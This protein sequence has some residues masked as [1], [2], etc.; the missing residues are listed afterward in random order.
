MRNGNKDAGVEVPEAFQSSYR[1]YEE[2]KLI[3]ATDKAVSMIISSYR[4]Y[5]EWKRTSEQIVQTV[6]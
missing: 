6:S 4:T 5:E 2:W 3:S 1:T